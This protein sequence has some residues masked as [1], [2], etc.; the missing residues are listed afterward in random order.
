VVGEVDHELVAAR[1]E[2]T[3]Q[4]A[5]VARLPGEARAFPLAVDRVQLGDRRVAA[6][7]VARVR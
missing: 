4:P 7:H 2:L 5:L 1:L 6:Q 3:Q